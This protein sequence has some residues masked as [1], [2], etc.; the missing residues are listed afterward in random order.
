MVWKQEY[1]NHRYGAANFEL[2]RNFRQYGDKWRRFFRYCHLVIRWSERR[3]NGSTPLNFLL[4]FRPN[5]VPAMIKED[6]YHQDGIFHDVKRLDYVLEQHAGEGVKKCVYFTAMNGTRYAL[7]FHYVVNT[8]AIVN[9]TM[10]SGCK[11]NRGDG[12]TY[13]GHFMRISECGAALPNAYRIVIF[14]HETGNT[15]MLYNEGRSEDIVK[16][17]N[18][19]NE[20][21]QD[22]GY[23]GDCS[24]RERTDT[25]ERTNAAWLQKPNENNKFWR[26]ADLMEAHRMGFIGWC[27]IMRI[28]WISKGY[29]NCIL[30]DHVI[31]EDTKA[32]AT[33]LNGK[34]ILVLISFEKH[35][36]SPHAS[37]KRVEM[38][39]P[40]FDEAMMFG[41]S[42]RLLYEVE[43][44]FPEYIHWYHAICIK[45]KKKYTDD[46]RDIPLPDIS[47]SICKYICYTLQ[48]E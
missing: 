33:S 30:A 32:I 10:M 2:P 11:V 35:K 12:E 1:I 9:S 25:I 26:Y 44:P 40:L 29:G 8:G 34:P 21:I 16:R 19:A 20:F 37:N 47:E 14:R 39:P 7:H 3:A 28:L 42:R 46:V 17:Y 5:I 43:S 13:F 15:R 38:Y 23:K 36:E 4:H 48:N 22:S 27:S 45:R 31:L 24:G 6:E 41:R 18:T